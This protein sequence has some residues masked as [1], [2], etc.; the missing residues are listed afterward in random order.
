MKRV[1][2]I[3]VP[4]FFYLSM[5]GQIVFKTV[6]PQSPVVSGESFQV[7][8]II[9]DGDKSMLVKPPVFNN[10]RFVAGPN[11]YTGNVSTIH[12]MKPLKNSVYTLEAGKPG[13]FILPGATI[14]VNGKL[15]RS[16]D[17]LVEVI[18]QEAAVKRFN[19]E[20]GIANSD[21]FLRPGEDVYDKIRQNLFVKVMVNRKDCYVGEPVLATF[22]LYSRLESKSDIV[23]NP[24]FYGFTVYDMVNLEDKQVDIE[25]ING[26]TFNVHTI[27]K[28]QLYPLQAG[29]FSID[30]MEVKNK[31]E[32][33]RSAVNKRTEQ[34]V[35]EGVLGNEDN[36]STGSGTDI[37]ETDIRTEP[38]SIRVKPVPE[39]SKTAGFN[40]ATG[41][42]SITA[43]VLKDQL[44]KNEEGFLEIMINGRGNFIQLSAPS[45]NWPAGIEGFEPEVKDVFDKTKTPLA[46]SRKFRYPF[47]S[48]SP[49]DYTIPAIQFTFFNP[50]SGS[51]KTLTT[52]PIRVHI[53]NEEKNA[54]TNEKI[55]KNET[56]KMIYWIAG[57]GILLGMLGVML[58]LRNKK[59]ANAMP[60]ASTAELL[61]PARESLIPAYQELNG[62]NRNFYASLQRSVWQF[63]NQYFD[64]SGSE[65]KKEILMAKLRFKGID[66]NWVDK[67]ERLLGECETGMFT[68]ADL[69][70]DK[71]KLL[72]EAKEIMEAISRLL[73]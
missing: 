16:N 70:T 48:S 15:V 43:V 36:A 53:S 40:G 14:I 4:F 34:E 58:W 51:Y 30:P 17:V 9:E 13:K 24:G 60:P 22:K 49:A 56:G 10:F 47:V 50:D 68:R 23:K 41:Q 8:Y 38:L 65:M 63:F 66:Q 33:S 42:F 32:F 45:I 26:K 73:L 35:I 71:E 72:R 67:L 1:A 57:F 6:V 39:Q 44:Q 37:F 29:L 7:Q 20:N 25:N 62:N 54:A 2:T 59:S 31:V 52:A 46:G 11:I 69:G 19:K 27:R 28:V 64:L 5:A 61:L 12:G 3:L 18:S 55:A 21:Y